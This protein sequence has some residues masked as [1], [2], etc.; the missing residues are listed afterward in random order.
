MATQMS[1]SDIWAGPP[2]GL[3]YVATYTPNNWNI[4]I[5]D[6]HL[7]EIDFDGNW[8]LVGISACTSSVTRG[9]K[10]ASIFKDKNIPV[11]MGGFHVYSCHE[12]ALQYVD[13]VVIGE[14]EF[15]WDKVIEDFSNNSLQKIYRS[16]RKPLTSLLRPRRDLLSNRYYYDAIQTTRGCPFSCEFCSVTQFYGHRYRHRPVQDV[17]DEIQDLP[18]DTMFIVDDNFFG[19]SKSDIEHAASICQGMIDRDIK[20]KWVCQ[21]S[22]NIAK[23]PDILK[24]ARKAGCVS[25][26]IGIESINTDNLN[27]MNKSANLGIEIDKAIK[28]CHKCGIAIVGSAFFG[29]DYDNIH[30]FQKTLKFIKKTGVDVLHT[31]IITPYPGTKLA[32]RLKD[33]TLYRDYPQDWE[34]YDTEHLTLRLDSMSHEDMIRGLDYIHKGFYS[35]VPRL[36]TAIKTLIHTKRLDCTV[37]S[38]LMN[39]DLWSLYDFD[40]LVAK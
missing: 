8:D 25:I 39:K 13:S 9:Y 20:K 12:E 19:V 26:Y 6:E 4:K 40:K 18:K 17:L 32:D 10:I 16:E 21:S 30:S 31:G 37:Y 28:V 29:Y 1:H 2:L 33:K 27:L 24:L 14:A 35:F 22:I 38:Y 23:Y 34:L 36:I 15:I 11:V 7:D 5:I 3:A